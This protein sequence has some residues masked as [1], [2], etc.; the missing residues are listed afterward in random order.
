MDID[1]EKLDQMW[2]NAEAMRK[3]QAKNQ[4]Y[5]DGSHAISSR[6]ATYADGTEKTNRIVN[7]IRAMIQSYV[8][9]LTMQ[10][11]Q[12]ATANDSVDPAAFNWYAQV[13]KENRVNAMD[14][15]NLRWAL[16]KG[17][18]IEIHETV[19]AAIRPSGV[20]IKNDDPSY[21]L[22]MRPV[23]RTR[24]TTRR[25]TSTGTAASA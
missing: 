3:V 25:P 22:P 18:G 20:L 1:T 8:G 17:Y 23:K 24:T 21:W 6:K 13:L 10:P 5:F 14:V 11:F 4:D 7:Y 16:I 12:V 2:D 15:E 9:A 19:D